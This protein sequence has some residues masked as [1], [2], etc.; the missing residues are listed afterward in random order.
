MKEHP[1]MMSAPMILAD[2]AGRKTQTRR[3]MKSQPPEGEIGVGWYHPIVTNKYGEMEPGPLQFGAWSDDWGLR[4]PYGGLGDSIW[5]RETL[6]LDNKWRYHADISPVVFPEPGLRIKPNGGIVCPSIHMPRWASRISHVLTDV[7][8][9]RLG[10]I[11]E[12]DAVAEGIFWTDHD[13]DRYGQKRRG[14]IWKPTTS[15]SECLPCARTAYAN[16]WD[17]IHGHGAWER[18]RC[19]WVWVLS[20]AK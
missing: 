17:S 5:V 1:I 12:A 10:D 20:W 4:C 18:D 14:W 16:L 9:E 8:C 13:L 6:V 11:S 19:K 2:L 3:L 7:R 15:D